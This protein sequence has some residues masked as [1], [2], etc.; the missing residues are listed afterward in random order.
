MHKKLHFR[1]ALRFPYGTRFSKWGSQLSEIQVKLVSYWENRQAEL[2]LGDRSGL[3]N[4][5]IQ[6]GSYPFY[7]ISRQT[8]PWW[9]I[10]KVPALRDTLSPQQYWT[11]QGRTTGSWEEKKGQ[12]IRQVEWRG[13]DCELKV[14]DNDPFSKA[15]VRSLSL[16]Q[17]LQGSYWV[18]PADP[19]AGSEHS[20]VVL[21]VVGGLGSTL[22]RMML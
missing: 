16:H 7:L 4:V 20:R 8:P 21:P 17:E 13:A 1:T 18:K 5:A 12:L 19:S 15:T 11:Q 9:N 3:W 22:L 6:P 14:G 2:E 10:P